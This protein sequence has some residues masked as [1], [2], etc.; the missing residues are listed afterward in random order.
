MSNKFGDPF[1]ALGVPY[2]DDFFGT[3]GGEDTASCAEGVDTALG[4]LADFADC[5]ALDF[6]FS[7]KVPEDDFTVETA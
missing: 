7:V 4:T 1:P 5:D 2:P 6:A 3:S